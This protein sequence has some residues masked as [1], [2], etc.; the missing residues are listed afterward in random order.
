[1]TANKDWGE[2]DVRFAYK[3][4]GSRDGG[5]ACF[6][7]LLAIAWAVRLSKALMQLDSKTWGKQNRQW[8]WA[9]LNQL[10]LGCDACIKGR[11]LPSLRGD[12]NLNCLIVM[13]C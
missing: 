2:R 6:C 8:R 7:F 13:T 4:T 3:P 1:M 11:G 10:F 9:M 5:S 12:T